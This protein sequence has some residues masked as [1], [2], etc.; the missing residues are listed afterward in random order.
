MQKFYL[1]LLLCC[2]TFTT[3][4]QQL[5]SVIPYEDNVKLLSSVKNSDGKRCLLGFDRNKN[6]FHAW[7]IDRQGALVTHKISA[8][9]VLADE[10]VIIG[11]SASGNTFSFYSLENDTSHEGIYYNQGEHVL[12]E[13][14]VDLDKSA[15]SQNNTALLSS[16]KHYKYIAAFSD[17][18]VN[19]ALFYNKKVDSLQVTRYE[20]L[21]QMK[22]ARFGIPNSYF[23]SKLNLQQ[24]YL[25]TGKENHLPTKSKA[26]VKAYVRDNK[27]YLMF[28]APTAVTNLS[29][30]EYTHIVK[31]DIDQ[32]QASI[33]KLPAAIYGDKHRF[34]SYLHQDILF[35]FGVSKDSLTLRAYEL[36]TL[37]PLVTYKNGVRESISF[38]ATPGT[39]TYRD[40]R[41]KLTPETKTFLQSLSGAPAIAAY[42][43]SDSTIELSLGTF[44]TPVSGGAAIP[45]GAPGGGSFYM[46]GAIDTEGTQVQFKALLHYPSLRIIKAPV[47]QTAY[48]L[49][50]DY[51]FQQH[52][53][54]TAGSI[55]MMIEE[56]GRAYLITRDKKKRTFQILTF[57]S[58]PIQ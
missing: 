20:R 14:T 57:S 40:A 8:T 42:A 50:D 46:P 13:I 12:S 1:V 41:S 33:S 43:T 53:S 7:V 16:E 51:I 35:R 10:P 6:T 22:T 23:N 54:R 19:Y 34:S 45:S 39:S 58:A 52:R 2:L 9:V 21:Q 30:I 3:K 4:A 25:A 15:I 28:D 37:R 36:E 32:Q 11:T 55:E 49:V 27:L 24:T 47:S 26:R 29:A 44:L 56:G 38:R 18:G 5:F 48:D 31:L 17:N